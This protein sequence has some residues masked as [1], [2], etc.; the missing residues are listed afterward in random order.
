MHDRYLFITL[1][2]FFLFFQSHVGYSCSCGGGGNFCENLNLPSS[3]HDLAFGDKIVVR[4]VKL[5][6]VDHGI[7]AQLIQTFGRAFDTNIIR[8]WSGNGYI[9]RANM[10]IIPVGDT[11]ILMM[12]RLEENSFFLILVPLQLKK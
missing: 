7:D 3:D 1:I 2:F 12:S 11:V 10:N 8:V 6:D 9:C 4:V 5:R